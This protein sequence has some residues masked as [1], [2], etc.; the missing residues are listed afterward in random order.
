MFFVTFFN[1]TLYVLS[2]SVSATHDPS[3]TST[4]TV[5]ALLLLSVVSVMLAV[6]ILLLSVC[7]GG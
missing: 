4:D 2:C 7:H 5:V 1:C 3:L 6:W